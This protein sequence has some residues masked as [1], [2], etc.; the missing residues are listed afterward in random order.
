MAD[1]SH[2]G[3]DLGWAFLKPNFRTSVTIQCGDKAFIFNKAILTQHSEY[4]DACLKV[5]AFV[6]GRTSTI[7]FDD[8]EPEHMGSYLHLVYCMSADKHLVRYHVS[9]LENRK[10]TAFLVQM[11]QIADRF[12]SSYLCTRIAD[13][14]LQAGREPFSFI[15]IDDTDEKRAA[16]IKNIKGAFEAW[17]QHVPSQLDLRDRML[18]NF[19]KDFPMEHLPSAIDHVEPNS[20]FMRELCKAM[21]RRA[22]DLQ[23][24]VSELETKV[25]ELENDEEEEVL[26]VLADSD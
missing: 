18:T 21:T 5:N 23:A 22:I 10:N 25:A 20:T 1:Q 2:E 4:F 3:I 7:T 12:I 19:A 14:I 16:L 8:I 26:D 9:S 24:R 6:E 11:W 13:E 17:N 15:P